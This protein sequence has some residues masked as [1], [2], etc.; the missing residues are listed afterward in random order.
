MDISNTKLPQI[1]EIIQTLTGMSDSDAMSSWNMGIP[2]V[3]ACPESE[4][5]AIIERAQARGMR[6]EKIGAVQERE[7]GAPVAMVKGV[8]V[9]KSEIVVE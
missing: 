2:Y 3:V 8:G 7:E 6:A 5:V 1:I 4:V 9:M